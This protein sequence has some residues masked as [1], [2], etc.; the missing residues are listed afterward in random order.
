[1]EVGGPT[2]DSKMFACSHPGGTGPTGANHSMCICMLV[3]SWHDDPTAKFA[4]LEQVGEDFVAKHGREPT[5][6]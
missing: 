6:W 1:M 5:F 3:I 2:H 4:A